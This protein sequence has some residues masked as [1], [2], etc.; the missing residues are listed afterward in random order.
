MPN[1][2]NNISLRPQLSH[3]GFWDID[4]GKLDFDRYREFAI[5]RVMERGTLEDIDEIIRYYGK[6]AVINT[7]LSSDRLMP[8]AIVAAKNKFHLQ[9]NDFSCF[10]QNQQA[11]NYSKF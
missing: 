1:F 3:F 10:I 11:K 5:T 7:L 6:Q 2:K 8:R 4:P 9:D